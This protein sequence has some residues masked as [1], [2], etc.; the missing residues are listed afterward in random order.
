MSHSV[1]LSPIRGTMPNYEQASDLPENETSD[2][3]LRVRNLGKCFRLYNFPKDKLKEVLLL[4]RRMHFHEFWAVKNVSFD[5]RQGETL[6][7][8][9][10]NGSGKSTLLQIICETM[11]PTEGT[12]DIF[13]RVSALLELGSGFDPDFTGKENVYMNASILGLSR[14]EIDDLYPEI[15][16]FADIGD[17]INQP[18]RFYS[19]GMYVRLAFAIAV[20]VEPRILVVDEALA[21]GDEMF[22][23]KCFARIRS[24]KAKGCTILFVSH[25]GPTVIDLCDRA[26]LFDRGECILLGSPKQ[27]VANY[28]K[29]INAPPDL[30]ENLRASI[31]ASRGKQTGLDNPGTAELQASTSEDEES[32]EAFFDP[33]LVPKTTVRYASQGA[34]ISH[35]Q[36]TTLDGQPVNNL[37]SGDGYYYTYDVRFHEEAHSVQFGML[38]KT[39]T[40]FELGGATGVSGERDISVVPAGSTVRVQ[41]KFSCSLLPGTYFLNCDV[42][43]AIDEV[44]VFLDRCV[45]AVIFRVQPAPRKQAIGIVDFQIKTKVTVEPQ[46]GPG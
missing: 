33:T 18:V 15:I 16:A 23:R 10:R 22:Q 8:V 38:I 1:R 19:S 4:G 20:T 31:Q 12:V 17:F 3:V 26:M 14:R 39:V 13:G 32:N 40:G 42:L 43:G 29:L 21:V 30:Q 36:I 9:G 5:L 44:D 11:C 37:V 45:D 7:I 41:M 34:T 28:L 6:G 35:P 46:D 27:V 25:S 2:I 24:L